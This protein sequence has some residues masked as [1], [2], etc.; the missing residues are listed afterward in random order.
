MMRRQL[1]AVAGAAGC[2]AIM[3]AMALPGTA[4]AQSDGATS[5][6]VTRAVLLQGNADASEIDRATLITQIQVD[7]Q[8]QADFTVPT[9]EGSDPNN[10]ES[11]G[12]PDVAGGEAVYSIDVD[13]PET[14]R[15]TQ[16]FDPADVPVDLDITATVDGRPVAP[17]ELAGV[18]GEVVLTYTARNITGTETILEYQDASGATV[19]EMIDLPTAMGATL[20]IDFPPQWAEIRS[21][22]A[23]VVSGD[24]TGDTQ[25][26]A[27]LTLFEPFGSPEGSVTITSQVTD[28]DMPPVN[29]KFTVLQ[30]QNN[31]TARSLA[32]QLE[33]GVATGE[34]IYDAGAQLEDGATQLE[35]GLVEATAGA[36]EIASGVATTLAP[37]VN[38]L[39]D[40]VQTTLVPGVNELNDGVQNSLVP[41]VGALVDELEALPG[42]VT[43]SPEFDQITGG[44]AS[45]NGAVEGVRDSLGVF[46]STG[47]GQYLTASGDID[48]S[49]TTVARTLWALIYGV[50]AVDTP[51]DSAGRT[52]AD[53]TGGLTN[54][55]CNPANPLDPANPCGA[56]QVI[57]SVSAG[58][59]GTAVPVLG[60]LSL[61]LQQASMQLTDPTAGGAFA[62]N[63]LAGALGC[64]VSQPAGATGP[65]VEPIASLA[66]PFACAKTITVDGNPFCPNP[67]DPTTPLPCN[68]VVNAV[69]GGLQAQGLPSLAG[70]TQS[71]Y[72][73]LVLGGTPPTPQPGSGLAA[74]LG[75]Y[76]P[77]ALAQLQAALGDQVVNGQPGAAL[78]LEELLKVITSDPTGNP[79][80]NTQPGNTATGILNETR[81]ALALGGVGSNG[82]PGQCAGYNTPG[83]PSSGLN[84]SVTPDQIS[85]TCA[86]ADVLNIA[87][88]VSDSLESGISTTLLGGI[89]DQLVAGVQPLVSGAG[90]LA[91]G[92]QQLADGAAGL[93]DGTQQLA[94]GVGPLADGTQ[95]L[96]EGLPAAVA[97]VNQI[98]TD[99]AQPLQEEGNDA[100]VGFA[101]SVAL[102]EAMNDQD[103][104]DAYIPGGPAE[105]ETVRTNGVYSYELAGT[106]SGGISTGVNLGLAL[107]GLVGA[108]LLGAF[109]G[110]RSAG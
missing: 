35:E 59:T 107:L 20:D 27:S 65:I 34:G 61:G 29:M 62:V 67:L 10:Q 79:D 26:S 51:S 81:A 75:Q 106:G 24:G 70:L 6:S 68:V 110:S 39:N 18:T 36:E 105:G 78:A 11:F 53:S 103:L 88:L 66:G 82:V 47:A 37:G 50:R 60:Q 31:P 84:E 94:D 83:D 5:T 72:N 77:G 93:A 7:G 48:K 17:S 91:D 22:E 23:T 9:V 54:P 40:G 87:L 89:S 108:G 46:S 14:F 33:T 104:V 25:V 69:L 80:A 76:Y 95:Q 58:L 41:G 100:A 1:R 85:A 98:I 38:E 101:R 28:G 74:V 4:V 90:D 42:T 21:E 56:W 30:P 52:P 43:G 71:L 63:T 86:A 96:A 12:G 16:D 102:Y 3:A 57:K 19:T 32:G 2:T 97:G 13:G 99:A 64:T 8:G 73:P 109:L 44:F 45:L 49:R 55:A 92:S 15:T